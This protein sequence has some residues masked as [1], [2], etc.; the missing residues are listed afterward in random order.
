[1]VVTG[2]VFGRTYSVGVC[3]V[4]PHSVHIYLVN[5]RRPNESKTKSKKS[6][7]K[8]IENKRES[9][10]SG[11]LPKRNAK[12]SESQSEKLFQWKKKIKRRRRRSKSTSDDGIHNSKATHLKQFFSLSL[13]SHRTKLLL[14]VFFFFQQKN[15]SLQVR[16]FRIFLSFHIVLVVLQLLYCLWFKS[17]MNG[18]K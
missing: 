9:E 3:Y 5:E 12:A 2:S 10:K 1:M 6:G 8:R 4:V 11:K 13:S 17:K 18:K 7:R 15:F 14:Y 16:Y